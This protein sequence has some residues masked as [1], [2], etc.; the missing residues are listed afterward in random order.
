MTR[1][2]LGLEQF[3]LIPSGPV[4]R[5]L[6]A[7]QLIEHAIRRG[8]GRL[9]AHGAFVT[10]TVPRTGRSPNDKFIV[11]E[12]SS[13]DQIWWGTVNRDI[14]P[15]VFV[16]MKNRV[17][18]WLNAQ[19]ELYVQD[20]YCGWD[21]EVRMK[22]RI[23]TQNAWQNAFARN[24]FV[25]P[26]T[27]EL[28]DFEP[29]FTV[30]HAPDLKARGAEDGVHSD[31]FVLVNFAEHLTVIGGTRYA[32]EIKKSIFSVMN[33]KLPQ[34]DILPMHCS[35]NIRGDNTAIFFGLSGT[36]KTTLSTDPNRALIG[37]DEHGWG[38]NG[39]FNFEG[40]CYAK[41][42]RLSAEAEPEIFATS[43]RFGTILEN[44]VLDEHRVP[45]FDDGSLAENSRGSYP[46]EFIENRV[47][48]GVGGHPQ[49]VIF[50][51]AD[52][53]GVL[54][55]VSRLTPAQAA[56]HFISGYTAKV[57][58]TEVGVV[59]PQATFSSCFG[60]PFLPSHPSV[61]ADLLQKKCAAHG[62]QAWLINTGWTGGPY[63]VGHRISIQHTRALLN[64]VL[65]GQLDD[66]SFRT[67][68]RFGFEVPTSVPGVPDEILDPR[69]TWSDPEAFDA[70]ADRLAG[71]FNKN[72][73]QFAEGC[74]ADI[75]DAAPRT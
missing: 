65:D 45:D 13:E 59:E 47:V 14:T 6:E 73:E 3:G 21:P 68:S 16:R 4:H 24:M 32:G 61:Y 22:V 66:V 67:D 36:G 31:A 51:T 10:E 20:L 33:F 48:D 52:A 71:L 58:G 25:R 40:G 38:P 8:E 23:V 50:L 34:L 11:R 49:N 39:V 44:V 7:P 62:S 29:D 35:A 27:D 57:A 56:Y 41:M 30:L 75:R 70:Q 2:S 1:T 69:N 15:E 64:A 55:P 60:A 42:I 26:A 53:F 9:S 63:G 72:F 18:G 19:P 46:L 28:D 43:R 5:N 54:P 12:P 37:D 17:V 74:S